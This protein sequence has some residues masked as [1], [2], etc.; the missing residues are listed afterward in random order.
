M[1]PWQHYVIDGRRKGY[2]NG[3]H[4]SDDTFFPEGYELEY[5]DVTERGDDAWHHYAVKGK[6]EGRD[7]G[8]HPR[9][10]LFFA[11]GYLAMY[12]DVAE[13]GIDPWRHYVL[14]G[15]AEGRDCG[16][17]PAG[18]IFFAEGYR[19]MYPDVAVSGTDPWRHYVLHGKAEGRDNGLH[20][21][22][23]EFFPEGY[24]EMYPDVAEDGIDPWR[25]YVLCGKAEGRDNGL[26]P[27]DELFSASGYLEMYR[28]IAES[29]SDPWR[30][31]LTHGKSEGRDNGLHPG[32]DVFFHKGYLE[33]YPDVAGSGMDPW[34]H[35]LTYGKSEGRDN[36]LHPSESEFFPEGYL[37]M[38]RDV[39]ESGMNPWRHY[40]V[41]GKKEDRDNGNHPSVM[42]FLRE[43][44][45]LEYPDV[46]E[47]DAWHDYAAKGVAAG[48]DNGWH[49]NEDL[50][51]AEGY[52]EM[53]PDVSESG[54]EPWCHYAR[55][56]RILN[57]D[58]GLHPGFNQFFAEGYLEMYPEVSG[59]GM[60]AWHHY[61]LKGKK[62]GRDNGCHPK[63]EQFFAEGYLE[64]YPDTAWSG[65]DSWHHYVLTGK[66]EGR[67]NGLH[68]GL[69]QFFAD[70]YL[71][72]YPDV[73]LCGE[74]PW[75]HYMLSGKKEGRDNGQYLF[76]SAAS[77][78]RIAEYWNHHHKNR[79]VIYTCLAGEYDHLINHHYISNDY[80]YVC[81]TDN[82]V[83]LKYK[84][85]GV[86]K[87]LPLVFTEL[88]DTRNNRWHKLH[89]H[90][91]FPEY[92]ESVYVDSNI[93]ILT[94]YIFNVLE[95]THEDFILPRHFH[96]D[97][98]YDE[99][100]FIVL[101]RKDSA[102]NMK[103][104]QDLYT[105][106]KLPR[107]LGFSENNL[108]YR[109]HHNKT[110]IR[111]MDMW[112]NMIKKYSKRDQ[113]SLM[114]VM[115]K[116]QIDIKSRLIPNLRRDEKN[117]IVAQHQGYLNTWSSLQIQ[118]YKKLI[119]ARQTISFSIFDTL[120]VRPY[121]KHQDMFIHL[122]RNEHIPGFA[123]ARVQ[124]EIDARLCEKHEGG[125]TLDMIYDRID[126]SYKPLQAKEKSLEL[127][128][129]QP[130]PVIKELYDYA[131][132]KGKRVIAISDTYYHRQFLIKILEKN[133]YSRFDEILSSCDEHASQRDGQL[134]N[135]ALSK[136]GCS[137]SEMLHIGSEPVSDREKPEQCKISCA[138]IEKPIEHLF[139]VNSRALAFSKTYAEGELA[140]SIYLGLLA[141]NSIS[142]HEYAT[143]EEYFENLGYE[144][145]GIVAWQFMKFVYENCIRNQITD[146]AFV[147]REVFTLKKVFDLFAGQ[148]MNSQ[149]LYMPQA[150][151]RVIISPADS[152]DG[153]ELIEAF[154]RHGNKV[155][156]GAKA[157]FRSLAEDV[158]TS[159]EIEKEKASSQAKTEYLDYL[160]QFNFSSSKLAVVALSSELPIARRLF[161]TM[162]PEKEISGFCWR[163]NSVTLA[164][165]SAFDGTGVS[166]GILEPWAFM[167]FLFSEPDFRVKDIVR[168][169]RVYGNAD[170]GNERHRVANCSYVS[171]GIV[172]FVQDVKR[173]FGETDISFSPLM[174]SFLIR[175]LYRNPS[176]EDKKFMRSLCFRDGCDGEYK[177]IFRL[178]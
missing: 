119:D 53:Y 61:L 126:D 115:W 52:L 128:I 19:E 134:Y 148:Q 144:Y 43:G 103:A 66:K 80:D 67:D 94:D 177:R 131:L 161:E 165:K 39:A 13:S 171:D 93:N 175:S 58:N 47:E 11:E 176:A 116:N 82:P 152:S 20:P 125:I 37:T 162:Y 81:F 168:G 83:L 62:E 75:H 5:P 22:E 142:T 166:Y 157:E 23:K 85:Y 44:Y 1:T 4:P 36:G 21:G 104:L 174:T 33:M 169:N 110:I 29:R 138:V 57:R 32:E 48:R 2:D 106:E 78:E 95:N 153:D 91:L 71:E 129:C 51:F 121:L 27:G 54:M 50:F 16:L 56:G 18:S 172:R 123:K 8:I 163:A 149:Y 35:Y 112:W 141:I 70:G 24:L 158:Q 15:K 105:D 118:K 133:G 100:K 96:H 113:A 173:I 159:V 90:E 65:V 59:S 86:W 137:P 160:S 7:N 132:D 150:L 49:P 140:S 12:P 130:N 146:V 31:Y 68:P 42:M 139:K 167:E 55:I 89:P 117:F 92:E 63:R 40:V 30:H 145:G 154:I 60:D 151:G 45:I 136:L 143:K 9:E 76:S 77:D 3:N 46:A 114:Y 79:K 74:D 84:I 164:D 122:E 120:L 25:H 87:I 135:V 111:I 101:C 38:Y 6:K 88:D 147:S 10:D 99:L 170:N 17:H 178:W 109:K 26:H 28:D 97:C 102:E 108:L 98:I 34:R 155:K 107:H 72:M 127:Q 64:M 156:C 73:A 124:A 14:H 41:Y 69:G